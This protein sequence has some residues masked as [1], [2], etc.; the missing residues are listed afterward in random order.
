MSHLS[1][2]A[3]A[4]FAGAHALAIYGALPVT[5]TEPGAAADAMASRAQHGALAQLER[6]A[7][8]ARRFLAVAADAAHVVL[9]L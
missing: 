6:A 7:V 3:A 9:L 5:R 2:L 8:Q 4:Q 1:L